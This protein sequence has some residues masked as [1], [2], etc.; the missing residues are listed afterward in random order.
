[1]VMKCKKFLSASTVRR[2]SAFV[3]TAVTVLGATAC[4]KGDAGN[5]E[6]AVQ[7]KEWAYVPEFLTIDDESVDYYD[8]QLMG[9]ALYYL[10]YNWNEETGESSQE[11]C[12]YSLAD[13]QVTSKPL[14]W[15]EEGSNQS[16]NRGRFGADGS[17]YAIVY[18]YNEDYT[19]STQMLTKFDAEGKQLYA[20]DMSDLVGDSYVDSVAVDGD[21][22]LYVS[23]DGEIWLFDGDGNRQGTVSV[24]GAGDIW[25]QSMGTGRDGKVYVGYNNYDGNTSSYSLCLVDFEGKKLGEACE[26]LPAGDGF[27]PGVEYDFLIHNGSSVYGYNLDKKESE[28]LFD[29]LD[30][31][32]NGN[33]VRKFG[34][35]EDGRIVVVIE[36]WENNDNGVALLTKKKADEVPQK[37]EIVIAT[38]GGHYALQSKAVKFNKAS[39][40]YHISIK[41]YV[42]YTNFGENTWSDALTN[43]NNDLTSNNCPDMLDLSSVNVSQLVS[44]GVLEDLTPYLEKSSKLKRE[45]FIENIL[46]SYTY[47]GK[48]VSIPSYFSMQTVIGSKSMVGDKSGWT[49][50]ELINLA[51]E[52]PDAE[53]FDRVPK[54]SILQAAMMFNEE[55]FIDWSTGECSFDTD[56]FKNILEFV[57]RF[58]DEVNWEQGQDSEPTRIQN[59]EVLLAQAYL[60]DF[61]QLQMYN[62]IFQ[63]DYT[64]IGFPTV[65][66]KSGHALMASEA[67]GITTKS[68]KK[69]GAWEFLEGILTEEESENAWHSGFPTMKSKLEEMAKKAVTPDYV[70]DENG[71]IMKDENGEAIIS[72]GTS[73]VGYEDGWSYTYRQTTQEEVDKAMELMNEAKPV[74]YNGDDEISKIITEEAEAFFKGQK[75]VDEVAGIIQNRINI[76]VG[77]NR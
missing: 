40:K 22:R 33:Y 8:M 14:T 45:D 44:K 35:L 60:Y 37:E 25:I 39:D 28:Y 52:H 56:G 51:N 54:Q 57:N 66:G 19:E 12:K 26:G 63:G 59:G 6:G 15:L 20:N 16:L 32:I 21:G 42:D 55:A 31:D 7:K 72:S 10:S 27:V 77:E 46:D 75:S 62:E 69:E 34:Q 68:G 23:G 58:P 5:G 71:E 2:V 74:N 67:Y 73:S 38:M 48:L 3:L 17:M 70:T 50:E 76:Y 43:L 13:Q 24:S 1:M 36:D 49:M 18:S 41:E 64:C 9:D 61:D 29:W 65:D 11:I 4:G 53:L 47:D 30:S